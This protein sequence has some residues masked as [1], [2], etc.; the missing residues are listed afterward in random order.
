MCIRDRRRTKKEIWTYRARVKAGTLDE[1]PE[2][3]QVGLR[4]HEPTQQ[5]IKEEDARLKAEGEKQ[6][7][8]RRAFRKITADRR[9]GREDKHTKL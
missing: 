5:Q 6:S 8:V 3:L 2:D 7:R 1:I 4:D 9:E